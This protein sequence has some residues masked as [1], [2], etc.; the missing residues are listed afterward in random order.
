LVGHWSKILTVSV[1][2][3]ILIFGGIPFTYADGPPAFGDWTI[4]ASCTLTNTATAA[5]NVIVES[6]GV[7]TI[8]N[9]LTLDIDFTSNNL[10]V[11]AGGGVKIEAG[12]K[13]S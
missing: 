11:K 13:I 8:P 6:S 1:I 2:F 9:G 5:G 4:T 3:A 10:T 7:L 12:G